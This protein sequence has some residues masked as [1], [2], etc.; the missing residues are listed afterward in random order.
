MVLVVLLLG[1]ADAPAQQNQGTSLEIVLGDRLRI[2]ERSNISLRR[3]GSYVGL[4]NR[5]V[6]AYVSQ[7]SDGFADGSAAVYAGRVLAYSQTRRDMQQ[8]GRPIDSSYE[9]SI[10]LHPGLGFLVGPLQP[11]R[12]IFPSYIGLPS[13]PKSASVGAT[14]E[15][16]ARLLIDLPDGGGPVTLEI[17]VAYYYEGLDTF[18]GEKVHRVSAGFATRYP[19]TVAPDEEPPPPIERD[20]VT[21]IIGGHQLTILLPTNGIAPLFIRDELTEQYHYAAGTSNEVRGHALLF[22]H[23]LS[24]QN[25]SRIAETVKANLA[26]T[27]TT[28]IEVDET[29]EGTRVTLHDVHFVPDQAV[30]L[31]DERPR[32]AAIADTLL[33]L[34]DVRFLVVGH[35]AD[36]GTPESQALLSLQ[37][38]EV[39]ARELAARGVEA[40]RIDIEGR[41]G[42]EPIGDNGTQEGRAMNRRVEIYLLEQ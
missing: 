41:G 25:R 35:T 11:I 36:V 34:D 15:A 28:Q 23:G 38:A 17:V 16:P 12:A 32:L 3:N 8:V 1:V 5:Q 24:A 19:Y 4:I 14:W 42:S 29:G 20:D 18:D 22:V 21:R 13:L 10:R 7:E 30:I 26:A 39:M 31:P 27:E 37:R 9:A 40:V 33:R 2:S 6:D